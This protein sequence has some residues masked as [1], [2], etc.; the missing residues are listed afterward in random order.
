MSSGVEA[1]CDLVIEAIHQVSVSV[2]GDCD[3][4]VSEPGLDC[5]GVFA[6]CDEPGGMSV[7]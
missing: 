7:P 4:A 2:H 5:L 6:V 1:K 3:R